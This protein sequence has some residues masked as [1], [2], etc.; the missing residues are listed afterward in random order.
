MCGLIRQFSND[1]ALTLLVPLAIVTMIGCAGVPVVLHD[2][3]V[4]EAEYFL[5]QEELM[6]RLGADSLV[7]ENPVFVG[8]KSDDVNA[9]AFGFYYVFGFNVKGG[10]CAIVKDAEAA[11][12]LK[13]YIFA[14][15]LNEP[16]RTGYEIKD[17]SEYDSF[18]KGKYGKEGTK[19]WSFK[20]ATHGRSSIDKELVRMRLVK[21]GSEVEVIRKALHITCL[22]HLE[23]MKK[24]L[25][26][27]GE[28][29]VEKIIHD[30]Y[31]TEGA[32]GEGFPC[33]VGSG[34][35]GAVI[36]YMH[37]NK[38][39][40]RESTVVIDIGCQYKNYIADV[41]RTLPTSGRF[42]EGHRKAYQAVLDAQKECEKILRPG[43]SFR[44]LHVKAKGVIARRGFEKTV[45][46]H[47][48][49]HQLGLAVHDVSEGYSSPLR[50]GMVITIE[51]GIYDEENKYGIRIEDVYLITRDGFERLTTGAPR[52]IDEIESA[53]CGAK[54]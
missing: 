27:G 21:S 1:A 10:Y 44:E 37:N 8:D 48:I 5:R 24:L 16:L 15:D 39:V 20:P 36:H 6:K 38:P 42:T 47:G 14:A 11:G 45:F 29:D 40:E 4:G 54:P 7:F 49:G 17:L 3:E 50:P 35:N 33:V 30:V 18:L 41:T 28:A 32:Q 23:V 26:V 31:E 52:E 25:T 22:A 2:P 51:P 46:R 34:A 53:V 13:R 19:I 43:V 12:G 9:R